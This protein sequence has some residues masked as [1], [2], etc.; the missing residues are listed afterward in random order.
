M[1]PKS[2]QRPYKRIPARS[3]GERQRWQTGPLH[4][5]ENNKASEKWA[6]P[7]GGASYCET[8]GLWR[9]DPSGFDDTR[10]AF[11]LAQH[12]AR[13]LRLRHAHWIGPVLRKRVAQIRRGRDGC[14]KVIGTPCDSFNGSYG[15]FFKSA[16]L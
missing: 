7:L 9:F 8:S 6:T 16:A 11:A 15:R 5:F 10:R 12:E 14:Q 1:R 13:E 2:S 3:A 4:A